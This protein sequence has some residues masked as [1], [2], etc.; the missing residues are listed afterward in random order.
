[1]TNKHPGGRPLKFKSVEDLEKKINEY[2]ESCFEWQWFDELMRDKKGNIMYLTDKEGNPTTIKLT[3]PIK[4][5]VQIKPISITGLA[6]FLDTSRETLMDYQGKKKFSDTIKKAKEFCHNFV[7]DG[8]LSGMIN[9]TA[10]IFNLKNNYGWVDKTEVDNNI[11]GDV[12]FVNDMP[13]PNK[14]E[15]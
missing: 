10:G 14:N 15:S 1:M 13:R 11:K 7:E 2:F 6:V 9:P 8:L 4:K 3:K 12:T 5:K